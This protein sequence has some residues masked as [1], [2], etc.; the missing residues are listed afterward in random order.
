MRRL[1]LFG[2]LLAGLGTVHATRASAQ[3]T[4][5]PTSPRDTLFR[6]ARKLVSEGNG[7]AGRAIVDSLLKQAPEG[8]AAYGDALYWHGALAETAADAERD[9]RRVIVEYPVS[10][11][12][13]DAL[14]ALVELEQARGDRAGA[15]QHLQRFVREH[16]VGNPARGVAALAA[17]RLAFDQR[18]TKTGCS[19]ITEARNSSSTTDVELRNQIDYFSNRCTADVATTTP[20]PSAR[21]TVIP[22]AKPAT[23]VA[24]APA[25]GA[26][27]KADKPLPKTTAK[28]APEKIVAKAADS[29]VAAAVD[30]EPVKAPLAPPVKAP[31][32]AAVKPVVEKPV[33]EKP[34]VEKPVAEKPAPVVAAKPRGTFTI[35]LAAY[36]TLADAQQLVAKLKTKGVA[37]R[38][39]GTAKPFRVRLDFY[40]TRQAAQD[41]VAS[42]KARGIIGFVTTEEP[43]AEATSP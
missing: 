11:Y 27:K 42:L 12:A 4:P 3:S 15:L 10:L 41:E 28:T 32:K 16:Q 21:D 7:V 43:P 24:A 37:A 18:D 39:S 23:R 31:V 1:V 5:A 6:K 25:P 38:V 19:M 29:T 20:A 26:G 36:S 2:A 17:A 22:P 33:V 34:A 13:D 14:L 30:S 8:T 9:Y 40:L 35:Q